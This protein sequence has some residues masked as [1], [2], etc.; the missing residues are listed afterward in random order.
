MRSDKERLKDIQEAITA[1]EKYAE[2]GRKAFESNELIQAWILHHLLILGE[3][4][5]RIT[6]EF[7]QQHPAIPWSKIIGTRN[8]LIHNY[9][10]I[11][12]EVVWN[13]VEK[14]L[15]QLKQ[16]TEQIL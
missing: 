13:V 10:G 12:F 1:I 11:D 15:P 6:D 14:E 16:L 4:A 5:S 8:I 2:Q 7:Q 9:F 3:A